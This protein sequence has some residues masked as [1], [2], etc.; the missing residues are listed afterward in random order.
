MKKG[1]TKVTRRVYLIAKALTVDM[2]KPTINYTQAMA[3]VDS[4][5]I[6]HPEWDMD[7]EKT[8]KEWDK[9]YGV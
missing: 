7:E 5:A 2:N 3:A 9:V 1:I 4:V 6:E 8:W